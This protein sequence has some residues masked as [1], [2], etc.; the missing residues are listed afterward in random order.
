[1]QGKELLTR[2]RGTR[3]SIGRRKRLKDSLHRAQEPCTIAD[4]GVLSQVP[5]PIQLCRIPLKQL[6]IENRSPR[7]AQTPKGHDAKAKPPLTLPG[8]QQKL[9]AASLTLL[10]E[11]A[12]GG[13]PLAASTSTQRVQRLAGRQPGGPSHSPSVCYLRPCRHGPAFR[14]L[15]TD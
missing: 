13:L 5:L 4:R 14:C 10:Q 7:R 8:Q 3:N 1:M 11:R 9:C 2:A 12:F 6:L 15:V